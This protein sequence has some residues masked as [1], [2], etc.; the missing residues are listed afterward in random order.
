MGVEHLEGRRTGRPRGSKT[1]S[2]VRRDMMWAYH[3]LDD[4]DVKPPSAGAKMWS[5]LA[6][7]QP[8]NF[9]SCLVS[10]ETGT[11]SKAN[12]T[13]SLAEPNRKGDTAEVQTVAPRNR[14]LPKRVRSFFMD[15]NHVLLRLTMDG[16]AVVS[17]LP[18][19]AHIVGCK[20]DPSRDGAL[21]LVHSDSYPPV[22][23]GE[24]IPELTPEYSRSK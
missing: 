13:G 19:G 14:K 9:L 24:A 18:R 23:A 17:N 15:F 1:T 7:S 21:F 6:R 2:R 10:L 22:P 12:S 3:H 8:G 16:I 4:A 5:D 11:E 20:A